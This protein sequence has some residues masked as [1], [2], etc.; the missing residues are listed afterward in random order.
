MPGVVYSGER[1]VESTEQPHAL[2]HAVLEINT[3]P[4]ITRTV[5]AV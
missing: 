3:F 5:N 4:S 2:T 1:E